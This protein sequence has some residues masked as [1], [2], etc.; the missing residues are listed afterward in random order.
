MTEYKLAEIPSNEIMPGYHGRLVHSEH[1]SIAYWTVENGAKVPEHSHKN[2][3]VM[4]VLEGRFEL[5]VEGQSKIY[6][7]DEL[8]VIPP[9]AK[10][11]GM[12]LTECK[13]MDV[14]TPV[15]EEY[16]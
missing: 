4:Q 9:F 1:L 8:V 13:L 12:A 16:R 3:Q 11:S 10:H 6:E 2:E 15:R 7:T 5:T 14:F